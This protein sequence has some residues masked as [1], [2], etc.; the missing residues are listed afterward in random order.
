LAK[1][2][3]LENLADLLEN[4]LEDSPD[5]IELWLFLVRV[6]RKLGKNDKALSALEN[7]QLNI[8]I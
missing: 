5:A 8:S 3:N 6:Y 2:H 7:A 1:E 4:Y